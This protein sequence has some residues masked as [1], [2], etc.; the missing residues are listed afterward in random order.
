MPTNRRPGGTPTRTRPSPEPRAPCRPSSPFLRCPS[1]TFSNTLAVPQRSLRRHGHPSTAA[2]LSLS[3]VSSAWPPSFFLFS[4]QPGCRPLRALIAFAR[5]GAHNKSTAPPGPRV[6][7]KPR[8]PSGAGAS[9]FDRIRLTPLDADQVPA[10]TRAGTRAVDSRTIRRCGRIT[11]R[12]GGWRSA[13]S[14]ASSMRRIATSPIS[15]VGLWTV[16]SGGLA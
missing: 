14:R 16:V 4:G 13:G 2:T 7:E 8:S 3:F 15:T 5:G 9:F 6:A 10:T 1:R 12:A 11:S